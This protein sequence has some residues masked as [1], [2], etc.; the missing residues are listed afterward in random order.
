[1]APGDIVGSA[2]RK[3]SNRSNGRH[4]VPSGVRCAPG[5]FGVVFVREEDFYTTLGDVHDA[6]AGGPVTSA[7]CIGET[8]GHFWL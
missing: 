6:L 2:K 1:M 8:R 5:G 4:L 3:W 7:S